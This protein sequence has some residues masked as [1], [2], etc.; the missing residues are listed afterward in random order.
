MKVI[1]VADDGSTQESSDQSVVDAATSAFAALP[2]V[3]PVT[4]EEPTDVK[5]D[6]PDGSEETFVPEAALPETPAQ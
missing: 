2:P 3:A 4:P 6:E 5:V 1:L